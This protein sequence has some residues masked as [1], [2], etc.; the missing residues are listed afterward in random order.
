[1]FRHFSKGKKVKKDDGSSSSM[2]QLD[3]P[4]SLLQVMVSFNFNLFLFSII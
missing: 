1:M 3:T 2:S 4:N